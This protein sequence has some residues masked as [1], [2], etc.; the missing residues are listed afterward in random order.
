[1]ALNERSRARLDGV[2][3]DL[4]RVVERAAEIAPDGFI[5]T[6]GLRSLAR[7]KELVAKGASRTLKSRHLDGHA[8]DL[9]DLKAD[10]KMADMRKIG[11]TMKLAAADLGIALE[12]GGDWKSFVDTP[13]FQLPWKEYP[14]TGTVPVKDRIAHAVKTVVSTRVAAGAAAG[15]GVV[16]LPSLPAP[17]DLTQW[18][19]WQATGE[20]VSSLATWASGR[21]LLTAGLVGWV[22]VMTFWNK[23]P[24]LVRIPS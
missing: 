8:V 9:A 24:S 10:Y 15:G 1:M 5:V 17:P 11:A 19:A 6:E 18:T 3:P 7:Q 16:T 12:W 22:V 2:H 20:T 23:L 13:H 21:P 14:S 4:V